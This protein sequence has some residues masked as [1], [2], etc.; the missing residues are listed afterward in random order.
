MDRNS[1]MG[2][3]KLFGK[4]DDL[5]QFGMTAERWAVSCFIIK[6]CNFCDYYYNIIVKLTVYCL[7]PLDVLNSPL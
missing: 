2:G 3:G 7:Y 5:I 6:F 1:V 4:D